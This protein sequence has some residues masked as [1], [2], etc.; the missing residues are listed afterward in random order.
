MSQANKQACKM[1]FWEKWKSRT[2]KCNI[3][4]QKTSW[5]LKW[6]QS[7]LYNDQD[8]SFKS[9]FTQCWSI[10]FIK[11]TASVKSQGGLQYNHSNR[12]WHLTLSICYPDH[13]PSKNRKIEKCI[14]RMDFINNFPL[15][16]C[17][18]H[19]LFISVWNCFMNLVYIRPQ[20]KS[21]FEDT[22]G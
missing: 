18:R 20:N 12:C 21:S 11:W 14:D 19:I 1:V 4:S 9:V 7:S 6:Q 17:R 2:S 5:Q 15:S 13:S 10:C 16:S 22:A 3:T 8:D